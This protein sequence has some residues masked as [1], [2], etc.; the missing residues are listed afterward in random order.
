MAFGHSFLNGVTQ[1]KTWVQ[2]RSVYHQ[3]KTTPL[4]VF[5]DFS[6]GNIKA[7][8][9]RWWP[10]A[11]TLT[12]AAGMLQ[13]EFATLCGE[14]VN[15]FPGKNVIKYRLLIAQTQELINISGKS[16]KHQ[17]WI[18]QKIY[19]LTSYRT[20]DDAITQV[21]RW[22]KLLAIEEQHLQKSEKKCS[23]TGDTTFTD[24][25]VETSKYIGFQI[26]PTRTTVAQFAGYVK[27]F[28][29]SIENETK[30]KNRH[31]TYRK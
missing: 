9:R 5:I 24:L 3:C 23:K 14:K 25:L 21:E 4:S 10:S 15:K 16:A 30:N 22:K 11:K 31:T 12:I 20:I 17:K 26:D 27:S 2:F 7:L 13:M 8:R 6:D 19:E 1:A 29:R 28:K 18:E